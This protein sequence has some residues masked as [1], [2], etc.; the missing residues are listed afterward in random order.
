METNKSNNGLQTFSLKISIRFATDQSQTGSR[1]K[2]ITLPT[3]SHCEAIEYCI[4]CYFIYDSKIIFFTTFAIQSY[5]TILKDTKKTIVSHAIQ[6][7]T[8]H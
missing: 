2:N 7:V 6:T 8:R 3:Y 5:Q 1:L 4:Y